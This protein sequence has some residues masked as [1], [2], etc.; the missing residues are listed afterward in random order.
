LSQLARIARF[1]Q[2]RHLRLRKKIP[3]V[4]AFLPCKRNLV[5]EHL[6]IDIATP[7]LMQPCTR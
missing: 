2:P 6:R 7:A 1:A 4:S 3:L 5:L